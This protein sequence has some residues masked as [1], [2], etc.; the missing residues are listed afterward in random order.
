[1][2]SLIIV[3]Y[4]AFRSFEAVQIQIYWLNLQQRVNELIF[5]QISK[6][7]TTMYILRKKR[8]EQNKKST[9]TFLEQ[10]P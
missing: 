2:T 6:L 7:T 3:I 8:G 1:M 10:K 4:M 9:Q 5:V